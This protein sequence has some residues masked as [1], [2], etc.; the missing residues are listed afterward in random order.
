[1]R[2]QRGLTVIELPICIAIGLVLVG[3]LFSPY[4]EAKA[5]NRFSSR[6]ATYWDALVADLRIVAEK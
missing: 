4:F 3:H 5:F 1:M 2:G 6:K